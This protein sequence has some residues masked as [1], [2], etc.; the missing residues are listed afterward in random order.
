MTRAEIIAAL[1][2]APEAKS[3]RAALF[4][5]I[6]IGLSAVAITLE[7]EPSVPA[8]IQDFLFR[9]EIFVLAVFAAEYALRIYASQRRLRYIF[10]FWG[11]VDLMSILPAIALVTPQWQ[12]VRTIRLVR[13]VRLLKLLRAS[14]TLDRLAAAVREVRGELAM[15]GVISAL[16][17]YVSAVG[18][19]LFEHEAQPEVFS[20]ILTS[21]WWAVA[22]FTTV[23]YGDMVP[24]T[25]G[26]R[27]FTAFVLFIGLGIIAVP[28][29][30][31]TTA[32][33]EAE[34]TIRPRRKRPGTPPSQPEPDE[35]KNGD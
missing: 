11:L 5:H 27:L 24:I 30:I 26:G 17:L 18:I 19:Y 15:F 22:T 35:T 20:S 32:L 3:T 14:R 12:V 13:L 8:P 25:G 10:S 34:T 16:M 9:F 23:G 29:A 7:T 4:I 2:G 21:L 33:L 1:D 6:L 28:A 31:V